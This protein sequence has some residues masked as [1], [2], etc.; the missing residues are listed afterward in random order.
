[1]LL[2][3][4]KIPTLCRWLRGDIHLAVLERNKRL[5][6]GRILADVG[7]FWIGS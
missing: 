3:R 1:M 7:E 2:W 5:L 6:K 4:I